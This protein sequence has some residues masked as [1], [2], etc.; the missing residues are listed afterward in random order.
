MHSF[1]F[2]TDDSMKR[3]KFPRVQDVVG[4]VNRVAPPALAEDWDN[5]GLQLGDSA[6]EVR[7]VLVALDPGPAVIEEAAALAAQLVISHHPAIFRPLK[8]LTAVDET[9]RS[10]LLAARE[11]IALFCA[12]TNLDRTRGG[13]NDWLAG[14][15]GLEQVAVLQAGAPGELFKLA[16]FVPCG[17]EEAVATALFQGGAG[18]IG[19]YDQCSFRTVGTGTFRPGE[20]TDPFL[21]ARGERE[22]ARELRLETVVPR[23]ALHRVLARLLKAHPYEE[24]A[25]DLLPLHNR[26]SDVGLGRVGRLP[27][28]M[29]LDAFARQVASALAAGPLRVV[30]DGEGRVRKVAV[31]GGSGASLIG[32][33]GRQGVDVLVT[34]DVKYHEAQNALAQGVALVDAGHFA[35]ERIMVSELAALL[36]QG[37]DDQGWTVEILEAKGESDP[38]RVV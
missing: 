19:G 38:F 23:E 24:V 2:M 14:R 27:R 1:F 37:L 13:L 6:A 10:L 26:R 33:A 18:H 32:E 9:G 22:R 7:R 30:G 17:Y 29:T 35:T 16:V 12:H 11:Q 21:G 34:G 28:E 5:V 20:G 25:Y 3:Q 4:L 15:L 31:C 36:R 8:S